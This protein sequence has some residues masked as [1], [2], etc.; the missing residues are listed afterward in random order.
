LKAELVHRAPMPTEGSGYEQTTTRR[1]D[2]R[3]PF[4]RPLLFSRLTHPLTIKWLSMRES[5][6][7]ILPR[8]QATGPMSPRRSPDLELC[9]CCVLIAGDHA[10]SWPAATR[11][12]FVPAKPDLELAPILFS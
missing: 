9:S 3:Q 1:R 5:L 8:G 10:D 2:G 11:L 7:L 6:L 4:D 12:A